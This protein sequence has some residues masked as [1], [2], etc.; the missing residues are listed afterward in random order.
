MYTPIDGIKDYLS[1]SEKTKGDWK[2]ALSCVINS[3][4]VIQKVSHYANYCFPHGVVT[5]RK[6]IRA[7]DVNKEQAEQVYK[8]L[9]FF[10]ENELLQQ[11]AIRHIF[12]NSLKLYE[13]ESS[14][15]PDGFGLY[16][17]VQNPD[18]IK[19]DRDYLKMSILA[20]EYILENSKY[21]KDTSKDWQFVYRTLKELI[22]LQH[23]QAYEFAMKIL[24]KERYKQSKYFTPEP[25]VYLLK[26]LIPQGYA[27]EEA[28]KIVKGLDESTQLNVYAR[29]ACQGHNIPET[30]ELLKHEYKWNPGGLALIHLQNACQY[31]IDKEQMIKQVMLFAEKNLKPDHP[32]AQFQN[33]S[34]F[35]IFVSL[36]KKGLCQEEIKSMIEKGTFNADQSS[37]LQEIIHAGER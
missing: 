29:L 37:I 25:L 16:S 12:L 19:K 3:P 35:Q 33:K 4:N 2:S 22:E 8:L 36:A 31:L 9:S 20:S 17:L 13:F 28:P 11:K 23:P 14:T 15:Y 32:G 5:L 21:F 1:S 27:I 10:G 26:I 6:G 34:F 18:L 24:E 7:S 30:E